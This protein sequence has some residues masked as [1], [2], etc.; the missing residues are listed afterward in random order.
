VPR[1]VES[2][3]TRSAHQNFVSFGYCESSL[4]MITLLAEV[5]DVPEQG[6]DYMRSDDRSLL[7]SGWA[8][9]E[10]LVLWL[11]PLISLI[12]SASDIMDFYGLRLTIAAKRLEIQSVE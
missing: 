1:R 6:R 3:R 9:H 4:L 8:L 12:P 11:C 2:R 10:D 5:A 7:N